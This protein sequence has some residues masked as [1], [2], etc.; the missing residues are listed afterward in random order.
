[1]EK[2][3][4]FIQLL[5]KTNL[6][7][8]NEKLKNFCFFIQYYFKLKNVKKMSNI[9]TINTPI[10][11]KICKVNGNSQGLIDEIESISAGISYHLEIKLKKANCWGKAPGYVI[12]DTG[13]KMEKAKLT[14]EEFIKRAMNGERFRFKGCEYFYDNTKQNPFRFDNAELYGNWCHFNGENEFEVIPPKPKTKIIKEWK[15]R[16]KNGRI[17]IHSELLTEEEAKERFE[18]DFYF[19]STGREFE[20]EDE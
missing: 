11:T 18:K 12:I 9:I 8:F 5:K 3:Q 13:E 16:D 2:M 14:K 10:G 17:F 20:V 15:Y 19:E 4:D 7:F 6:M 1:M